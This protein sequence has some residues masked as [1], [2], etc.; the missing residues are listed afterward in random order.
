M[1]I[2]R[3]IS[4]F[5]KIERE[6]RRL[7][8]KALWLLLIWKMEIVFLPMRWYVAKFGK[9]GL[10]FNEEVELDRSL[11]RKI[12]NSVKRAD[13]I[14]PWKSKCLTEAISTKRLLERKSIRSTLYLGVARDEKGKLIA[15]AWLRQGK[16]IVSGENGYEKFTVVEKFS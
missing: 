3:K 2:I 8:F 14:L 6:E 12:Q 9:K 10:E 1:K 11:V 5:F 15:H 4:S 13:S 7:F 16:R